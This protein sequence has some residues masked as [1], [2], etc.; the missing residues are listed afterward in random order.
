MSFNVITPTLRLAL[1]LGAALLVVDLLAWRVVAAMSDSEWLVTGRRDDGRRHVAFAARH[2]GETP[3]RN[4][5]RSTD[6][7]NA[8]VDA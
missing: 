7:G 3:F 2:P 1:G 4:K 5:R 8:E 6:V